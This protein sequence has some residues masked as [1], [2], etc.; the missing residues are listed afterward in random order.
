MPQ[1]PPLDVSGSSAMGVRV[2][3]ST[4][5]PWL[6]HGS[7]AGRAVQAACLTAVIAGSLPAGCLA[8]LTPHRLAGSRAGT[9]LALRSTQP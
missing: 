3:G 4:M 2:S 8:C 5:S 7:R 1:P 9:E 6:H